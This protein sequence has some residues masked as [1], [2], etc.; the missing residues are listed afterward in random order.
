M[1]KRFFY[2]VITEGI[3]FFNYLS[4]NVEKI[5]KVI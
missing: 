3:M 5:D 2:V 1:F 4:I